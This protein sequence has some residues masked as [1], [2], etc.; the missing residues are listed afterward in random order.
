MLKKKKI[1]LFTPTIEDGG[2]EKNLYNISNFLITKFKY[3]YI[4]TANSD[5]KKKFKKEIIYCSPKTNWFNHSSRLIKS[6]FS[7]FLLLNL[8]LKSKH[9]V[10]ISF[11]NNIFAI[12]FSKIIGAKVIVRTNTS[13]HAYSSN[14]YKTIMFKY[15]FQKANHVLVNS[16]TMKKE[17][18]KYLNI[19][20]TCI[21]NPLERAKLIE[22]KSKE[23]INFKKHFNKNFINILSIGRLVNQKNQILILK[24]LNAI[25]ERVDARLLIIGDGE[26]KNKLLRFI[27]KNNLNKQIKIIKFQKN[28]YPYLKRSDIFILSSNY[29]GLPNVLIE[30]L[31]LSKII[32]STDC[33][34]GPSEI[35]ANGK[36]GTLFPVNDHKELAKLILDYKKNSSKFIL[37]AMDGFKSLHR[38]DFNKN[39]EKYLKVIEKI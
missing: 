6:I 14:K 25:K 28:I 20:A 33:P 39:C 4:V 3:V 2:V 27:K 35:L 29:E 22:N 23:K 38:F 15:F 21:Y 36:Y 19:N 13:F 7:F 10:V 37:K 18:K 1:I 11:N 32:F 26:E 17:M 12:I 31:S 8:R 24:A 34:T 5:K 16:L 9:N 30:A